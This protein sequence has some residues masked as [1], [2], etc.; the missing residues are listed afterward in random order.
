M[1]E[2]KKLKIPYKNSDVR[3]VWQSVGFTKKIKEIR[4]VILV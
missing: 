4:K 1:N 3:Y 2:L